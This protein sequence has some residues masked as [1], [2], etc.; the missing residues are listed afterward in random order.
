MANNLI[1]ETR[2]LTVAYGQGEAAVEAVSDVGLE[3]GSGEFLAIVGESG[4]GKSTLCFAIA[5]LL[6]P[7][8]RIVKG[9]V[10]FKGTNLVTLRARQ[11]RHLRWR[12]YAVV[13]QS[14]MNALNPVLTIGEQFRDA[15]A[16]HQ[17]ISRRDARDRAR[18]ALELVGVAKDHVDS[19]PHQLSGG[20]RQRAMVAMALLFAPDLLIMDE[21]TSALDVVAQVALMHEIKE[22]QERIGFAL[23]FVTHDMSLVSRF[24]DRIAV[25]YAGQLVELNSTQNLFEAL[26][27]YTVALLESFP[28]IENPKARLEGIPGNPPDLRAPIMGCRFSPRCRSVM[29]KCSLVQP[30]LLPLSN[31]HVRC[32]LYADGDGEAT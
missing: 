15:L 23:V 2:G 14:A 10:L 8:G 18:E 26:H 17:S 7:A 3:I 13:M 1:L 22:L 12:D 27:P 21:P 28:S 11:L 24:S 29:Q 5:Q 31:A 6:P 4:C 25:M 16:A 30:E 19:Y 20:M 9:E 32:H